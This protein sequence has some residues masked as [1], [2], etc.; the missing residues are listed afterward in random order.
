MSD[1][2]AVAV[3]MDH[4]GTIE[5]AISSLGSIIGAS[6]ALAGE[7]HD[8]QGINMTAGDVASPGPQ[9]AP[10]TSVDILID[11]LSGLHSEVAH[12]NDKLSQSL[13]EARRL[14]NT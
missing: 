4:P 2:A 6:H 1:K 8:A 11:A 13:E 3:G 7:L 14:R 12:L 5:N 9:P 10:Q